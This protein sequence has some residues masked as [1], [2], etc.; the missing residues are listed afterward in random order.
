MIEHIAF[1]MD[2]NRRYSKKNFM[3]IKEGYMKGMEKFLEIVSFQ[4]KY[5]IYETSFFALSKENYEK[6]SEE[7]KNTLFD[8]INF[9]S[10]NKNIK[11]FFEENKIKIE[12]KGDIEKLRKKELVVKKLLNELNKWNQ[13]NLEYK[14]KV[15]LCLNY[16]GQDEILHSFKTILKKIN[17]GEIKENSITT[18]TIKKNLWFNENVEPQIIVRTGDAPRIS[19]FMLWDSNYSEIYFMKKLWPEF[20]ESD[21]TQILDWYKNIKRNFG[22]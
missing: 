16:N 3:S 12:L 18:Q 10:E 6:R 7:E 4:I 20:E 9:F 8:L 22:K 15:N 11:N 2:G 19:G 5:N 17:L 13:T 21:F 14:F 1:I